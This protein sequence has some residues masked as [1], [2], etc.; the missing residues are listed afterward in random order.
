MPIF[1]Q[2]EENASGPD[3]LEVIGNLERYNS[4]HA[5]EA[6]QR[7]TIRLFARDEVGEIKGGLF[8][9]VT[10]GWLA[11]QILWLDDSIRRQGYGK[12]LL[13]AAEGLAK[14]AEAIGAY[15][16]TTNF[17]AR[18][19]YEGMGYEVFSE[20]KDCPPG[21]VTYFLKKRWDSK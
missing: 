6:F 10:M 19:F 14:E 12:R 20:L 1:I 2:N 11:I 7:R 17:Q 4:E 9:Q 3:L 21:D 15:V 13:E 8:A 5:S 18:P 16:E